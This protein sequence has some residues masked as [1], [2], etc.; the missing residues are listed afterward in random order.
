MDSL[1]LQSIQKRVSD[2]R[3][4][5]YQGATEETLTILNHIDR[6]KFLHAPQVEALETYIYLKEIVGNKPSLGVFRSSFADELSFLRAL[7]ISDKE[8]LELAYDKKKDEKIQTIL[9]EKFGASDYANQVYA[10]TMGS[11]KTILMATM[12]LYDFVLSFHHPEDERFAKNILVFA[13][14]TTI[15]DSLKEIKTLFA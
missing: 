15:I 1:F 14:D 5:G 2:W 6:V 13:P 12:M 10:L 7:G 9:E 11:G 3:T 4:G 8:A